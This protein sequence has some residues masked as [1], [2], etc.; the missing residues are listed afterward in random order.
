MTPRDRKEA[1]REVR[2]FGW[3]Y[4]SIADTLDLAMRLLRD[5]K[6]VVAYPL[7]HDGAILRL[8][9]VL[10]SAKIRNI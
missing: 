9:P 2:R 3:T 5:G 10:R 4:G 7:G 6:A 8:L 1:L